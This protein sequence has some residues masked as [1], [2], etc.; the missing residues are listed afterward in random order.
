MI[1]FF[2]YIYS[3]LLRRAKTY[4]RSTCGDDRLIG[5]MLMA[6]QKML[7]KNL[8]LEVLVDNFGRLRQRR[9]P[10]FD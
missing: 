4:I 3:V 1:L 6:V 7:V 5:L 8:N 9:Y 10:L 2:Q